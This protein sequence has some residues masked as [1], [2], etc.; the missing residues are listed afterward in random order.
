MVSRVG[1]ALVVV[2]GAVTMWQP[3]TPVPVWVWVD[4]VRVP[5]YIELNLQLV[6]KHAPPP[7]FA[8][9]LVN[10]SSVLRYLPRL[11]PAFWRLS[12]RAAPSDAARMALMAEHGGVYLDADFLVA[13]SLMPLLGLLRQFDMVVY[14]ARPEAALETLRSPCALSGAMASTNF[15]AARPNTSALVKAWSDLV[16]HWE[17]PCLKG[18]GK[19]YVCCPQ[20]GGF[21]RTPWALTDAYLG[22]SIAR[23]AK[24]GTLRLKCLPSFTPGLASWATPTRLDKA[25]VKATGQFGL[26]VLRLGCANMSVDDMLG[27]GNIS[28]VN[29]RVSICCTRRG[30]DLIMR[31]Q[32]S[33][34]LAKRGGRLPGY[35]SRMAYHL[36]ESINGATLVRYPR[37][38]S[39]SLLVG[40]LYRAALS[41]RSSVRSAAMLAEFMPPPRLPLAPAHTRGDGAKGGVDGDPLCRLRLFVLTGTRSGWMRMGEHM[42]R[43]GHNQFGVAARAGAAGGLGDSCLVQPC[44][45]R[46]FGEVIR[47]YTAEVPIYQRLLSACTLVEEAEDADVIVLPPP[48]ATVIA[49]GWRPPGRGTLNDL[50]HLPKGLRALLAGAPPSKLLIFHTVDGQMLPP[51]LPPPLLNATWVHLGDT[52]FNKLGPCVF[53]E[54]IRRRG[55]ANVSHFANSLTVPHRTSQWMPLG[56]PPPRPKK[57]LLLFANL[58]ADKRTL[59]KLLRKRLALSLAAEASSLN[60]SAQLHM[61]LVGVR[62]EGT[63]K[64][65]AAS[66]A[67]TALR[68]HFC[69]CPSGDIVGFTARLFFS[70]IHRCIPVYVDLFPRTLTVEELAFPFPSTIDWQRVVLV[71]PLDSAAGLLR[72]L[73]S[74]PAAELE[75]RHRY[76]DSIASFLVYDTPGLEQRDAPAAFITE[77]ERR[78]ARGGERGPPARPGEGG[79]LLCELANRTANSPR[80]HHAK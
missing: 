64:L 15:F 63:T 13:R 40:A 61:N 75:A 34:A 3:G 58:N 67:A 51:K 76:A 21:C 53:A 45:E 19:R 5:H 77:L 60:L 14:S 38:E 73:A 49:M 25:L 66:G 28:G 69:L 46:E 79:E 33:A 8:V 32:G 17:R 22:P 6:H 65:D 44:Q 12:H 30:D 27:K 50:S 41:P 70:I 9:H 47:S 74:M 29:A 68:S 11:P 20:A 71:R 72:D 42:Q 4:Y 59:G 39:S 37:P 55:C 18:R 78:F 2:Y 57:S 80:C 7:H 36:F 1:H 24:A 52:T 23:E 10:R 54:R 35:F 43:N 31:F 56:F 48:R 16:I 62:T 26:P